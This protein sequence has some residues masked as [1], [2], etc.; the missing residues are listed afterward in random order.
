MKSPRDLNLYLYD[1]NIWSYVK[2]WISMGEDQILMGDDHN[3]EEYRGDTDG[4]KNAMA[5]AVRTQILVG[6]EMA[7]PVVGADPSVE[8][9]ER[10]VWCVEMS[11]Q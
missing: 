9:G 2:T 3:E 4:S 6:E 5:T 1:H 8:A 7:T 10:G 11:W